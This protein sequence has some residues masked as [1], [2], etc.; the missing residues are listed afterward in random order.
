MEETLNKI[1]TSYLNARKEVK[2]LP[3]ARKLTLWRK[4]TNVLEDEGLI[5]PIVNNAEEVFDGLSK[6]AMLDAIFQNED[7]YK[8]NECYAFWYDGNVYSCTLEQALELIDEDLL[9]LYNVMNV[10]VFHS[11]YNLLDTKCKDLYE[12]FDVLEQYQEVHDILLEG[13]IRF[14]RDDQKEKLDVFT[15]RN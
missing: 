2:A 6:T 14:V 7:G 11:K 13:K 3:D 8:L 12:Y 15:K 1:Y 10:D 9:A 4:L 5:C